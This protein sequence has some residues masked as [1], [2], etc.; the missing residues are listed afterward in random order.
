MPETNLDRRGEAQPQKVSITAS[1]WAKLVLVLVVAFALFL[2]RDLI[3]AIIASVVIASAI[4]PAA[5]WA[6]RHRVPR[7]AAVLSIYVLIG[8]LFAGLFYFLFLPLVGETTSF[9]RSLPAYTDSTSISDAVVANPTWDNFS[10]SISVNELA[11]YT[12]SVVD[13]LSNSVFSSVSFIFGGVISFIL[14]V[15]LSFYLAVQDDGVGKFLKIVTPWKHENYAVDLWRRSQRKIGLWMQG[16]LLLGAIVAVL[17]YLGLLLIGVEHA[18]LLAVLAGVF[19]LIPLFGPILAAIPAMFVAF[20]GG[21]MTELLIVGGLFLI[22]QQFENHLIYP[23]VVKKVVGVPP[24]VSIIA[25]IV[26]G[27]LAGFI[28]IVI[29]VPIAAIIMELIADMEKRKEAKVSAIQKS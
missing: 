26:G 7:V 2:V 21:G 24:M 6:R 10:R 23:L 15:V 29:S 5:H 19:E 28:G 17:A 12:N 13:S 14:I 25:L 11:R 22:I 20:A 18:L 4:E 1:S 3:L 8:T 27:Q 16:Q 9:I